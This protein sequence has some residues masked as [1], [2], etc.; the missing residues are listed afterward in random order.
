M[1]AFLSGEM[2]DTVQ[3]NPAGAYGAYAARSYPSK[4]QMLTVH[5]Q[6]LERFFSKKERATLFRSWVGSASM[7]I[8]VSRVCAKSLGD[9]GSTTSNRVVT[10]FGETQLTRR[11]MPMG[12]I[13][14]MGNLSRFGP[15]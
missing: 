7:W 3:V 10:P 12:P 14:H 9:L 8:K 1:S 11:M 4:I 15:S 2:K 13:I 6:V 5:V